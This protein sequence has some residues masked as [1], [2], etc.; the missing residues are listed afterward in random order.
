LNESL[1]TMVKD[2][3]IDVISS[4]ALALTAFDRDVVRSLFDDLAFRSLWQRLDELG[5]VG[6]AETVMA[7]VDVVTATSISQIDD[8]LGSGAVA[9]EPVWDDDLLAGVILVGEPVVFVPLDLAEGLLSRLPSDGII[10]HGVKP[11]LRAFL[12]AGLPPPPIAF[13]TMLAAWLINPAQRAPS[14]EDLAYKELGVDV[15]TT[16]SNASASQGAFSFEESALDLETAARRAIAVEQ[17]IDPLTN[18]MEARGALALYTSIELP[19][20]AIL[21]EMEEAGV[22]LDTAFLEAFGQE[23]ASR[24]A[25]LQVDIHKLAGREFNVNSTLQLRSILFDE[26]GLPV[27]KKT[28]KGAAST[29]ASVLEKLKDEHEIVAKL[30]MFRELDKLRSTYVEAL[31]KVVD[32]DGRVRGRFNQT[33]AATGRLSMEQPNLQN[34]PA[35]SAEGREIRRAFISAPDSILFVADY[36]QIELRILAHLSSDP[37]LVEAFAADIDIHAATAARVNDVPL[38]DVTDEMRRTSKMINFGLLYG[39]EA[40]GLAQRLDIDRGDAQRHID[41]YFVQFP[42]VQAFMSSIVDEARE[43]GYTTTIL[44]R[45]RY[46]PELHSRNT[47][48]RQMGE[49]MA[50]NAPIQ[51]SAADVIK[52]AMIDI[53]TEF[54]SMNLEAEML[55]QI[56]DELVL[57]VVTSDVA[58]V[59]DLV[60]DLMEGVVDLSVPLKVSHATG[61]TLAEAQH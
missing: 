49:R 30:L 21:A 24:I 33:G 39:M 15:G 11:M 57:E 36:S 53:R 14:L 35:R 37:G 1:M 29:D 54:G 12:E 17:L 18:Q 4:D 25:V 48:D 26:L 45:R 60:V 42:K 6:E 16:E 22:A 56:H 58:E 50:L 51:G 2:A 40:F 61:R 7:E 28:P 3:P 38:E 46:L 43:T 41:E 8:S 31:L 47:R 59:V 52:K 13:D 23:L 5:G 34:I 9:F 32:E 55:L 10:G 20:I 44:G 27:L 19:L